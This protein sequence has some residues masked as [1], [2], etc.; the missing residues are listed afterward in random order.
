MAA[1]SEST[2]T[3]ILCSCGVSYQDIQKYKQ[4]LKNIIAIAIGEVV[5]AFSQVL[6]EKAN[7]NINNIAHEKL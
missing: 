7:S 3:I 1:I 5:I 2:M 4:M 6:M